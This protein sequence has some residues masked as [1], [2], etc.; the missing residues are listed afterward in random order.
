MSQ[1]DRTPEITMDP[2]DLYRE[3]L[4]TDRQAGS[5]RRLTPVTPDGADDPQ[6]KV[7]YVGQAQLL[8]PVGALPLSFEIEADSL[9]TALQ[10]YGDA[11]Q[12]A[13]ERAIQELQE[14]RREAAS[15]LVIPEGGA[16]G[17]GGGLGGPGGLGGGGKIQLR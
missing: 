7:L 17:L 3:E 9:A 4:F 11:A 16:G 14:M 15:S 2:Q 5:L 1:D 12:E 10:K 8:T 6:R 13:M